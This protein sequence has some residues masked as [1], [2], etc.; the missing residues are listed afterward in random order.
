MVGHVGK[1][2]HKQGNFSNILVNSARNFPRVSTAVK[3]H[4]AEQFSP[5]W[6][7]QDFSISI[8]SVDIE[9]LIDNDNCR[10]NVNLAPHEIVCLALIDLGAALTKRLAC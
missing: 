7:H 3:T 10:L 4:N 6:K 5:Q 1:K 2:F 8:I 9:L